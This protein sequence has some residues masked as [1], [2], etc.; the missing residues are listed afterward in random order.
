MWFYTKRL[1]VPRDDFSIKIKVFS[2]W[3]MK[4]SFELVSIVFAI[5]QCIVWLVRKNHAIIQ[6]WKLWV[7]LKLAIGKKN[8]LQCKIINAIYTTICFFYKK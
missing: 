5:F 1:Y 8:M 7:H 4:V 2:F 3:Y 6:M